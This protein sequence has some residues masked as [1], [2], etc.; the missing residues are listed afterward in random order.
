MELNYKISRKVFQIGTVR[1]NINW[2]MSAHR[3][4]AFSIAYCTDSEDLPNF[5]YHSEC[6]VCKA[7][8]SFQKYCFGKLL[9]S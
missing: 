5:S 9:T 6:F 1:Y 3:L 4:Q 8:V 7:S 2:T